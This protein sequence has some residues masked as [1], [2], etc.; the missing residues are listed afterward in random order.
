MDE[1]EDAPSLDRVMVH[2]SKVIQKLAR[3]LRYINYI[4]VII[5]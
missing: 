3:K 2:I 1:F 5:S 4:I